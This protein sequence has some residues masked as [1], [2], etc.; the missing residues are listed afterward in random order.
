[1]KDGIIIVN[2]PDGITSHDVVSIVRRKLKM[3]RVGHAGTLDPLATGVLIILLGK[4]TKLF[5]EFSSFDK[6]YDATLMLGVTTDTADIQGKILDKVSCA[7]I[8]K[9]KVEEAFQRFVGDIEQMPPMVSAVKI[10]GKRL[11]KLAR[12]GI[13]VRREPRKVRIH[14]LKLLDFCLPEVKFYVECSKGTYIRKLAEDV[15]RVLGCGG[16]I[17]KINK[18]K[19]GP[20]RIEESVDIEK[21]TDGHIR[22]WKGLKS[23]LR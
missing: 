17:S 22:Q 15:G 11:Y 14:E 6:A 19:I 2:K 1:M 18:T 16:C 8:T 10:N 3:R 5:D 12:K 21:I 4:S 23:D 13:E 9:E 7:Q 20:F